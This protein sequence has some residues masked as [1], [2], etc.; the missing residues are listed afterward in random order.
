MCLL[1]DAVGSLF[2]YDAL[3]SA[4]SLF[5]HAGS[6]CSSQESMGSCAAC[7]GP[8]ISS[9]R[10][11]SSSRKFSLSDPNL[12]PKTLTL[13]ALKHPERSKSDIVASDVSKA[14]HPCQKECTQTLEQPLPSQLSL[15]NSGDIGTSRENMETAAVRRFSS[16]SNVS[17]AGFDFDVS[18]FFMC[19]SPLAMILAYRNFQRGDN[20]HC[21]YKWLVLFAYL[22][23]EPCSHWP[24][25]SLLVYLVAN[26]IRMRQV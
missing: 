14:Y 22:N 1:A 12:V 11:T 7:P 9:H 3:V 20:A 26:S 8:G 24:P 21:K 2:A 13:S 17:T 23:S 5:A 10:L 16:G 19:G 4:S 18:D 6:H 25:D 15:Q